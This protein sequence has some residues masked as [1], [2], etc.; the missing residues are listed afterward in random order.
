MTITLNDEQAR[1]LSE[2][3]KAG[4]VRS[5][6]VERA[7]RALHSSTTGKG[8]VHRQLDNLAGLFAKSR[9][10]GLNMDFERD[11]DTGRDIS[12]TGRHGKSG[13]P[14]VWN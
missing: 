14:T 13:F 3:V 7:V 4:A 12:G 11:K 6:E 2:V 8:P 1:P 5:P 9:F 10:R